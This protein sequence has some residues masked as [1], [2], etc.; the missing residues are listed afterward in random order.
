LQIAVRTTENPSV[1]S[2]ILHALR[3][4]KPGLTDGRSIL[5]TPFNSLFKEIGDC[6]S[7]IFP[8]S[9]F[10]RSSRLFMIEDNTPVHNCMPDIRLLAQLGDHL[11]LR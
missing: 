4:S 11:A 5:W 6:I 7:F 10:R 2:Y 9:I 1:I 3:N 8:S